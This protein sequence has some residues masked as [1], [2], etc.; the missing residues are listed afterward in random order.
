[1]VACRNITHRY[2][3]EVVMSQNKGPESQESA[4]G[5]SNVSNVPNIEIARAKVEIVK[6]D[7]QIAG[8]ELH[9]SNMSLIKHLPEPEKKGDVLKALQ[10]NAVVKDRVDESAEEL[11]NITE[12]LEEEVAQRHKLEKALAAKPGL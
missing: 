3:K 7:L 10:R 11:A 6:D 2:K 8:A 4:L 5:E 1:M 12:L 9:L